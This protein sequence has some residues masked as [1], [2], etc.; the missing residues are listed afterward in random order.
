[1]CYEALRLS[2]QD[3]ENTS[4]HQERE[5]FLVQLSS[6]MAR[7]L[8]LLRPQDA[9]RVLQAID[10]LGLIDPKLL[11]TAAALVPPRLDAYTSPE[12]L[13]LLKAYASASNADGFMVPCLRR[14]LLPLPGAEERLQE[15]DDTQ[16]VQAAGA[17]ASLGHAPGLV[18][19]LAALREPL[20][21]RATGHRAHGARGARRRQ[22]DATGSA[23]SQ[24][25]ARH[26]VPACQLA[27][28]TLVTMELPDKQSWA[29]AAAA[30]LQGAGKEAPKHQHGASL[31]ER[32]TQSIE[33]AEDLWRSAAKLSL[34]SGDEL[35]LA[36]MGFPG[37][38]GRAVWC[39]ELSAR[40]A[41]VSLSLLPGFLRHSAEAE[42]GELGAPRTPHTLP[43]LHPPP[44]E[45][46]PS[47]VKAREQA[48]KV[49]LE[50][51]TQPDHKELQELPPLVI[52]ALFRVLELAARRVGHKPKLP[53]WAPAPAEPRDPAESPEYPL[54][55]PCL[56]PATGPQGFRRITQP[57]SAEKKEF[58][59]LVSVFC[60]G[61]CAWKGHPPCN[62][63]ASAA[64]G[65]AGAGQAKPQGNIQ[66]SCCNATLNST[67][68]APP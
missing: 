10:R 38:G 16:V 66:T 9:S 47:E 13:A 67:F 54:Q 15:L 24:P 68:C 7:E 17:F 25:A 52:V 36:Y 41:E 8:R 14:A 32:L 44:A 30:V 2:G 50:R 46:S 45:P 12:L 55:V 28:A 3:S 26:L 48:E 57:Y 49:L 53:L 31:L 5:R 35:I 65:S 40:M 29:T 62:R 64:P 63:P 6:R 1:M 18:A 51:L 56:Q 22:V 23:G 21:P 61:C 43:S 42:V 34:Y 20:L 39:E 33:T 11:A 58:R 4:V 19:L 27:L 37:H 59:L 60:P